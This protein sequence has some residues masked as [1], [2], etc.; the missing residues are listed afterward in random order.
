[1]VGNDKI[2]YSEL[3]GSRELKPVRPARSQPLL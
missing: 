2:E 3:N 1:M